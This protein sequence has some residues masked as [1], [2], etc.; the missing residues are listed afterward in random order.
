L[1]KS[2]IARRWTSRPRPYR[3]PHQ[4]LRDETSFYNSFKVQ[5]LAADF[6]NNVWRLTSKYA[7]WNAG[8]KEGWHDAGLK[9][10]V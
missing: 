3:K 2:N 1:T 10:G 7:A 9:R 5:G 6:K 4:S 8:N